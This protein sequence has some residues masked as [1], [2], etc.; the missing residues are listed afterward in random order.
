MGNRANPMRLRM[1]RQYVTEVATARAKDDRRNLRMD[2]RP[3]I[4]AG[5]ILQP[6]ENPDPVMDMGPDCDPLELELEAD[7]DE[8]EGIPVNSG[9]FGTIFDIAADLQWGFS[10]RIRP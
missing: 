7:E 1:D 5:S 9:A 4:E 10:V 2:S 8:T 3:V 6:D